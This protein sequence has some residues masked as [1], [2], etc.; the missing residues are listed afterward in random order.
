MSKQISITLSEYVFDKYL[1]NFGGKNRSEFIESMFVRGI[2]TETSDLKDVTSKYL[3]LQKDNR[4]KDEEIKRLK[5]LNARYFKALGGKTPEEKEAER[6]YQARQTILRQQN[7]A[8]QES[9]LLLDIAERN[10][11]RS[12]KNDN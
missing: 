9:G 2:E 4:F 12:N 6:E 8:F 3:L 5:A 7:K 1:L 10:I 11:K